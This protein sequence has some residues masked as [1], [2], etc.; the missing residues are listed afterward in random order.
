MSGL[1]GHNL[2]KENTTQRIAQETVKKF[3]MNITPNFF[4]CLAPE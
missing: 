2:Q 3:H 1:G 4:N